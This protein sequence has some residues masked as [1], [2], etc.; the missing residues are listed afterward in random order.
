[1]SGRSSDQRLEPARRAEIATSRISNGLVE[2][3]PEL[4]TAAHAYVTTSHKVG[5]EVLTQLAVGQGHLHG[6]TYTERM[7][8]LPV[9]TRPELQSRSCPSLLAL[10]M[11]FV[12][13]SAQPN[14][15][16]NFACSSIAQGWSI[17]PTNK[18]TAEVI[19]TERTVPAAPQTVPQNVS[20]TTMVN[21]C[22]SKPA[23][24]SLGSTKQPKK[25]LMTKG[26]A[27]AATT[28]PMVFV[29]SSSTTGRGARMASSEPML[30]M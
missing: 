6:R 24:M 25:L 5:Y 16:S 2:F 27:T 14:G 15:L 21:G 8:P 3:G 12:V 20:A 26:T 23:A 28:S 22:K 9:E 10:S 13:Q 11:S 29:G 17:S 19:G 4:R 30:G 1:M 7:S 18:R